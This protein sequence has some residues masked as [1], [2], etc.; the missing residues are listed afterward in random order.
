[1]A[2][3]HESTWASIEGIKRV[4]VYMSGVMAGT[5]QADL[6]FILAFSRACHKLDAE[7]SRRQLDRLI[8]VDGFLGQSPSNWLVDGCEKAGL[9]LDDAATKAVSFVDDL[10]IPI[11][12]EAAVLVSETADFM[13]LAYRLFAS[14]GFSVNMKPE[15]TSAVLF[16]HGPGTV[17]AEQEL[18][19]LMGSCIKFSAPDGSEVSLHCCNGY[20]HLGTQTAARGGMSSEVCR[21]LASM[22]ESS[23]PL[24]PVLKRESLS[25]ARKRSV[26]N[27]YLQTRGL[28]QCGTWTELKIKDAVKVHSAVLKLYRLALGYT[29]IPTHGDPSDDVIV[30]AFGGVAPH[31]MLREARIVLFAR[32]VFK[33]QFR[34]L[35]TLW[36]G[37]GHR[38]SWF[39]L[40]W[41]DLLWLALMSSQFQDMQGCS[42]EE[43]CTFFRDN[44]SPGL[45]AVRAACRRPD[46][47]VRS[48]WAFCS[49]SKTTL[50]VPVTMQCEFCT[51]V[52]QT[53]QAYT[54]HRVKVHGYR[55]PERSKIN[56]AWCPVCLL[57]CG[58]RIRVL[59]HLARN[60][61]CRTIVNALYSPLHDDEIEL[62]D[63]EDRRDL[64]LGR[65]Q[66]MRNGIWKGRAVRAPG[67]K[68]RQIYD[69]EWLACCGIARV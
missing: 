35:I 26:I 52:G 64:K 36:S 53:V 39:R 58:S 8:D 41:Q 21:R 30:Q 56:T 32:L 40:L 15:K 67:P 28:Y 6:M 5:P 24:L 48:A 42:L 1:V 19:H 54:L 14:H 13:A 38:G 16:F 9:L 45:R 3:S 61:V 63:E 66:G 34:I 10:T 49:E 65:R 20:K 50:Q 12:A 29:S 4:M 43:W 17:A 25:L 69:V 22:R 55:V 46:L 27:V 62:L 2:E 23:E 57:H 7:L 59:I 18:G 11:Y 31:N 51:F 33:G 37:R 68:T 60:E 47:Q 44:F